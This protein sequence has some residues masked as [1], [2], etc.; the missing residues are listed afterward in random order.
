MEIT[1]GA[2]KDADVYIGGEFDAGVQFTGYKRALVFLSEVREGVPIKAAS[3]LGVEGNTSVHVLAAGGNQGDGSFPLRVSNDMLIEFRKFG[4]TP[5]SFMVD[6]TAFTPEIVQILLA[7]IYK[8][9]EGASVYLYYDSKRSDQIDGM[10]FDSGLPDVRS[11]LGYPGSMSPIQRTHL[12]IVT[13]YNPWLIHKV[14]DE[15]EPSRLSLCWH[16]GADMEYKKDLL[17]R[18]RNCGGHV[19]DFELG[20]NMGEA[21]SKI[22]QL[23]GLHIDMNAII[24]VCGEN[25]YAAVAAGVALDNFDIQLCCVP[26]R[27]RQD[28]VF[29]SNGYTYIT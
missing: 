1:F 16:I 8:N 24:M 26:M 10:F 15:F 14:V 6:L 23:A 3:L 4:F 29:V 21:R 7:M 28:K 25:S 27:K 19:S 13:G 17:G 12:V 5:E 11:V 18:V 9:Y 2:I 20:E 22:Q